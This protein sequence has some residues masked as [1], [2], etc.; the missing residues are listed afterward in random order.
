MDGSRRSSE[1][2]AVPVCLLAL[3]MFDHN[4]ICLKPKVVEHEWICVCRSSHQVSLMFCPVPG[5]HVILI[6]SPLQQFLVQSHVDRVGSCVFG[7]P[8]LL[9]I[10]TCFFVGFVV[11]FNVMEECGRGDLPEF[12][13]IICRSTVS[14]WLDLDFSWETM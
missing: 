13:H 7:I 1:P 4:T 11:C 8:F 5:K 9:S 10:S 12:T 3:I 2:S 14:I 6:K